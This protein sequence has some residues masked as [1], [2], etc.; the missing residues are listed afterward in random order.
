[1]SSRV[2]HCAP[3]FLLAAMTPFK[4]KSLGVCERTLVFDGCME[5]HAGARCSTVVCVLAV[6]VFLS[7]YPRHLVPLDET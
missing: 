1:M 4:T 5:R 7:L 2:P 3:P 6:C